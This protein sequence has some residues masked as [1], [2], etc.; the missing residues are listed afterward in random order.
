MRVA[1][2]LGQPNVFI[3]RDT[4]ERLRETAEPGEFIY[5]DPPYAP[6]SRT[7]SF[8]SY[9]AEGLR[10]PGPGAAATAGDRAVEARLLWCSSATP[11]PR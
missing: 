8:R 3:F 7:A 9:T 11:S 5:F 10:R 2:L 6:V 4:F 1:A